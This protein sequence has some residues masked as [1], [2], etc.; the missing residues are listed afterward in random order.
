MNLH[1]D[2]VGG[3]LYEILNLE[4]PNRFSKGRCE[5]SSAVDDVAE[6]HLNGGGSS[7][8]KG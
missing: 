4:Q 8:K 3:Q 2:E 1:Y 6:G 5:G 7:E